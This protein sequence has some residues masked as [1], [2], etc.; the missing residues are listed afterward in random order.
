MRKIKIESF[1]NAYLCLTLHEFSPLPTS[2]LIL[3]VSFTLHQCLTN[4]TGN[5]FNQFCNLVN[6]Y[7]SQNNE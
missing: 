2:F 6:E 4:E 7:R 3:T 1:F 5:I